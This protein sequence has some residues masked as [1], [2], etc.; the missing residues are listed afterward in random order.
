MTDNRYDYIIVGAGSASGVIANRLSANPDC[1]VLLVEAGPMDRS[2][3]ID[4]PAAFSYPL[5]DDKF[6][7][8]YRT[9]PEPNMDAR[10]MDSPRGRVLGGSSSINGMAYVRGNALDYDRW[11]EETGFLDWSYS[12]VLPYFKSAETRVQ[13]ADDYA[14]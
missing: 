11:S 3:F 10:A 13:G 12:H 4:M 14:G 8:R 1:R 6:N 7:W 5:N 2:V 9:E